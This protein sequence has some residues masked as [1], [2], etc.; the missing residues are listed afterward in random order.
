VI[1]VRVDATASKGQKIHECHNQQN[2]HCT[3]GGDAS[4]LKAVTHGA[5]YAATGLGWQVIGIRD[6]YDGMLEPDRSHITVK[7]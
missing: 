1:L 3:G 2:R 7:S 4:G 5:V 6:G